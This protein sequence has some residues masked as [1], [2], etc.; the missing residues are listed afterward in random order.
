MAHKPHRTDATRAPMRSHASFCCCW[1]RHVCT[2]EN[3]D[4]LFW[5]V[6]DKAK[7]LI[8]SP[9]PGAPH[10]PGQ[11]LK[12]PMKKAAVKKAAAKKPQRET[13]L[14]TPRRADAGRN[15]HLEQSRGRKAGPS[16]LGRRPGSATCRA[17]CAAPCHLREVA[18]ALLHLK[19]HEAM[20]SAQCLYEKGFLSYPR[21]DSSTYSIDF[22]VYKLLDRRCN[23][24][25]C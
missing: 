7:Q 16:R 18:S 12:P 8:V 25:I 19:P 3:A 1:S 9:R 21:T 10:H 11:L 20:E 23:F 2:K 4:H 22:D 24:T 5:I 6:M 15:S 14:P 13:W 17:E